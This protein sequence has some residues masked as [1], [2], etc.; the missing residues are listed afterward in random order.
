MKKFF[1][2]LVSMLMALALV[3]PVFATED[4]SELEGM[5]ES[6]TISVSF[7]EG[8]GVLI[9]G[10]D[11]LKYDSIEFE[12]AVP[13]TNPDGS[14]FTANIKFLNDDLEMTDD[15]QLL[16]KLDSLI[17]E[18]IKSETYD[19]AVYERTSEGMW[20]ILYT[21]ELAFA[22]PE[23]YK[24]IPMFDINGRGAGSGTS[25][26]SG[27]E[28]SVTFPA[29][30]KCTGDEMKDEI[31]CRYVD[32]GEYNLND[33]RYYSENNDAVFSKTKNEDGSI[34]ISF[35]VGKSDVRII[36]EYLAPNEILA[37][38]VDD[39][40]IIDFSK[41]DENYADS[42]VKGVNGASYN[43]INFVL[44]DSEYS[45][46]AYVVN[47]T[48][49]YDGTGMSICDVIKMGA[50]GKSVEISKADLAKLMLVN[51]KYSLTLTSKNDYTLTKIALG[52]V[53]IVT[54]KEIDSSRD[55]VDNLYIDLGEGFK[56]P[57]VGDKIP[58]TILV[59]AY[60]L[61]DDEKI[62]VT[63]VYAEWAKV[64]PLEKENSEAFYIS[65]TTEYY[66]DADNNIKFK[67]TPNFDANT[68]YYLSIVYNPLNKNYEDNFSM[69]VNDKEVTVN[70]AFIGK[71]AGGSQTNFYLDITDKYN[72]IIPLGF[73]T[74]N[75]G[76]DD[77]LTDDEKAAVDGMIGEIFNSSENSENVTGGAKLE[78]QHN[79]NEA[80]KAEESTNIKSVVGD[81]GKIEVSLRSAEAKKVDN[82][83]VLTEMS[84]DVTPVTSENVPLHGNVGKTVTFRLP[85]DGSSDFK[86]ANVSHE[87]TF[88]GQCEVKK[89][90]TTGDKYIE[91]ASSEFSI[92]SY[93]LTNTVYVAPPTGG[94]GSNGSLSS[95]LRPVVNTAAK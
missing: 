17:R 21:G 25:Y 58:N 66:Y 78:Y 77:K 86:Y 40:L 48:Q 50:D 37:G 71:G 35:K 9:S 45:G 13:I 38:F 16:V 23:T 65:A 28:D 79:A 10:V 94:S 95:T 90:E 29:T 81:G 82:S 83:V 24:V 92:F 84:F 39:K 70:G 36:A 53:E 59:D 52:E 87:G 32:Q 55:R 6:S 69:Y 33:V 80:S 31:A 43:Q 41:S 49:C 46:H 56:M 85:V 12:V 93:S 4:E 64:N 75:T 60:T 54:G 8:K 68:N 11:S 88:L 89:D 61:V 7:V 30:V 3:T 18:G 14:G 72:T 73:A 2:I 27:S 42:L 62:P 34:T 5:Q 15:E 74:V 57:A 1:T 47:G 63:N 22:M 44:T 26:I 51:G 91:V 67:N 20:A 76:Y 19:I